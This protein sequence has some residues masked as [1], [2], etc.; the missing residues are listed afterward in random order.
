MTEASLERIGGVARAP[1]RHGDAVIQGLLPPE[2]RASA[3]RVLLEL[4]T[5][6]GTRVRRLEAELLAGIG[7]AGRPSTPWCAAAWSSA[8]A[9]PSR[10]RLLR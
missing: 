10:A 4:V 3:R 1:A 8:R 6:E 9:I 2:Q 5:A 7:P